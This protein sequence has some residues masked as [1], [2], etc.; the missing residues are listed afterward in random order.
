MSS[1][2]PDVSLTDFYSVSLFTTY[3]RDFHRA[4]RTTFPH[5]CVQTSISFVLWCVCVCACV[6][7]C[8]GLTILWMNRSPRMFFNT[9]AS[10]VICIFFTDL[11]YSTFITLNDTLVDRIPLL[12]SVDV[13]KALCMFEFFIESFSFFKLCNLSFIRI[14]WIFIISLFNLI[15]DFAQDNPFCAVLI[16]VATF[17]ALMQYSI[18][19]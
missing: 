7:V 11:F 3:T 4:Q 9:W 8:R 10:S 18:T 19:E 5:T 17:H 12:L 6:C 1:A 16:D 13:V 15:T 2:E 14:L